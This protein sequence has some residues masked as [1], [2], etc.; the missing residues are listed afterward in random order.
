M[1]KESDQP[2]EIADPFAR[3]LMSQYLKRRA[4]DIATLR[5]A[6][7]SGDFE[8]VARSGHNLYGSGGAYG[9]DEI[10]RLGADLE[11]AGKACAAER[12]RQIIDDLE[13]FIRR[14][15]LV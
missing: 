2:I 5:E 11:Q 4:A 10:S 14:V 15:T 8:A 1:I 9:L 7:A 12:A 6:V 13:N 3:R